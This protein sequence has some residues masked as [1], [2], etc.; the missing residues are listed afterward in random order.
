MNIYEKL[1][2]IQKELKAPKGQ[3]NNF[4][5]YNYRSCEDILEAVKPICYA[6]KTALLLTDTVK[7]IDGRFY[8]E[9]TAKLINV[10]QPSEEI[11][12]TASARES[13]VKKGMDDSQITGATSSYARKYALNGLFNIDDTKDA[14]TDE[15][16]KTTGKGE[17]QA[18]K[19]VPPPVPEPITKGTLRQIEILVAQYA[20]EK[21]KTPEEVHQAL[22]KK[23]QYS[24]VTRLDNNKGIA[25]CNMITG[26]LRKNEQ[27]SRRVMLQHY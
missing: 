14:D 25:L 2:E 23:L 17:T 22:Q 8:V 1:I 19:S 12:V 15:Y 20:K 4:G 11:V 27:A 18:K 24:D 6:N 9:A 5:N 3:R 13:E 7:S 21:D 10:E 26:W 16:G